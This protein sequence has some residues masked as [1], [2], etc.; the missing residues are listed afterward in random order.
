[1]CVC[2]C[3]CVR[4][5]VGGYQEEHDS[6]SGS[7]IISLLVKSKKVK[8][9]K[10]VFPMFGASEYI[11]T[12]YTTSLELFHHYITCRVGDIKR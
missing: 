6:R 10:E 11:S 4:V 3:A 2:V 7:T 9:F 8:W 1:M 12:D 5:C